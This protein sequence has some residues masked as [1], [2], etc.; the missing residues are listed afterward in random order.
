MAEVIPL[1]PQ[2]PRNDAELERALQISINNV[3]NLAAWR[4]RWAEYQRRLG[5]MRLQR[6]LE[7]VDAYRR[8]R[9]P[10][11]LQPVA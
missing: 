6:E 7:L 4:Q 1:F 11:Q 10:P 5:C 2:V 9:V 3:H 8:R